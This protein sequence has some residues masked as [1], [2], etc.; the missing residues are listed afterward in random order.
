MT[1]QDAINLLTQKDQLQLLSFYD[2]LTPQ[3]Q[4]NLL[5]QIEGID[6]S[7]LDVL[8]TH[9]TVNAR[10]T[11]APLSAM[12]LSQI[13]ANRAHLEEVGLQAIREGKV[14]AVL[15]AGGQGTRLGSDKPK[16]MYNIGITKDVYIFEMIVRNL[17][18]VVN[19]TGTWIP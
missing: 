17:M 8:K 5:A 9:E 2:T 3:Q 10:G 16:G 19:Q 14:A 1:K 11:F 13:D 4:E 15:L 12:E 6:W 7:L 18:D